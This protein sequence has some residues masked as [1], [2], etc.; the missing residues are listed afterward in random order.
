MPNT[1]SL[2]Q[3]ALALFLPFG[4]NQKASATEAATLSWQEVGSYA[5][6]NEVVQGCNQ[7]LRPACLAQQSC[8][9]SNL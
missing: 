7:R 5:Q 1:T 3:V 8:A 9:G 2:C 6:H 4:K